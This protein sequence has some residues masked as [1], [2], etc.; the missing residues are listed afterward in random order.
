MNLRSKSNAVLD[1]GKQERGLFMPEPNSVPTRMYNFWVEEFHSGEYPRNENFCHFWRVVVFWAPLTWLIVKIVFPFFESKPMRAVGR[2]LAKPFSAVERGYTSLGTREQRQKFWSR[3]GYGVLGLLLL[4]AAGLLVGAAMASF[5]EFLIGI[6][7]FFGIVGLVFG[8]AYLGDIVT[9]GRRAKRKAENDAR[10]EAM[11][12]GE[13][14]SDEYIYG[15]K[16]EP[17]RLKKFFAGLGDFFVLAANVVRV[18]KWKI[19]PLVEVPRA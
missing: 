18:K 15:P 4:A 1:K 6:G 19:C 13:I 8:L 14:S 16:K 12:R 3:V 2:A 9:R 10:L 5:W 7:L 11:L 17:G